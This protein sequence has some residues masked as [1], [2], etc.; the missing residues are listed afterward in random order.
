M[1]WEDILAYTYGPDGTLM[2]SS[3]GGEDDSTIDDLDQIISQ[4]HLHYIGWMDEC[5]LG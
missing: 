3:V 2:C 4:Y 5:C 1:R